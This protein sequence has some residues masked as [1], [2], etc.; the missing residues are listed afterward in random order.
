MLHTS[1]LCL[2][3]RA[4][5]AFGPPA[6]AWPACMPVLILALL[7]LGPVGASL[8]QDWTEGV[9]ISEGPTDWW[10]PRVAVHSGPP[11]HN[12][13]PEYVHVV[14]RDAAGTTV[15]YRR[16]PDGGNTWDPIQTLHT[17]GV[18][19]AAHV[20]TSGN[21]VHVVWKSE[22]SLIRYRR[23]LNHGDPDAWE[24]PLF[25]PAAMLTVPG[26][27][28]GYSP[29]V[30]AY[31]DYVYVVWV[32]NQWPAYQPDVYFRRSPN[33]GA[34]WEPGQYLTADG[35]A[36]EENN[37]RVATYGE[38]VHVIWQAGST[39]KYRRGWL[40]LPD[41][42]LDTETMFTAGAWASIATYE[43][44]VWV[45]CAGAAPN[46]PGQKHSTD[47]GATFPPTVSWLGN[48]G[49]HPEVA[50]SRYWRGT[51]ANVYTDTRSSVHRLYVSTSATGE[52]AVDTLTGS[53][54]SV[55]AD[56]AAH[57]QGRLHVAVNAGE[58]RGQI[59]YY[60]YDAPRK[61]IWWEWTDDGAAQ[62]MPGVIEGE[63]RWGDLN[64]D[65]YPDLIY[66][67]QSDAGRI[68]EVYL[69]D[70]SCAFCHGN[71]YLLHHQ[72]LTGIKSVG[73][74]CLDLGDY[75][76]DGDLD[77]V[78]AGMAVSMSVDTPMACVYVNDGTGTFTVD[79]AS[80]LIAVSG[81]SVAWG[82]YDNDGDLDL[83]I[84][85]TDA[86]GVPV[87]RLYK[88]HP[89]GVLTWDTSQTLTPLCAGS[90]EWADY[91]GD[92]DLDL[93]VTGSDSAGT[94]RTIFYENDPVGTLV[95]T[96]SHGLPGVNLSDT[97]W[98]D[99]DNDGD[100]DLAFTGC[101]GAGLKIS[102]VYR[103][104]GAGVFT[105]L[106]V[107]RDLYRSSVAWG[108]FDNDGALDLALCGYDSFG[109]YTEIYRNTGGSFTVVEDDFPGVREGSL[110][111]VDIDDDGNLELFL[112]GADWNNKYA[113]PYNNLGLPVSDLPGSPTNFACSPAPCGLRLQWS[114]ATDTETPSSGLYYN[115]RVGST[116]GGDD[117]FSGTYGTPLMGNLY[118]ATDWVLRIP[119]GTY[120]WSVQAVDTALSASEWP[121]EQVCQFL[122]P[123]GDL[124]CDGLVNAFDIDPFVQCLTTGVPQPGCSCEMADIN[125][126]GAVNAF[127]IDPFVQLLTGGC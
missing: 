42:W 52:T 5:R 18:S 97:A 89:L 10:Y 116:S 28:E 27:T 68:T 99:F 79:A 61:F 41:E 26:E 36:V 124:N 66:C 77:L 110:S 2:L 30:A 64:N 31:G 3:S 11:T 70:R 7:V 106:G 86:F 29:D 65:G 94:L 84:Q 100:L 109:L 75:D 121:E 104:D 38:Y 23:N 20:A 40:G 123:L 54:S 25:A 13:M 55:R 119:P 98:G 63:A 56:I 73:S 37:P 45:D 72:S 1:S 44:N 24:P 101:N 81:A 80:P 91:D 4:S 46:G 96:G 71:S 88:N 62:R 19:V 34:M 83:Y 17:T 92:G 85:G 16:S 103:N 6:R 82:D 126:D 50:A 122:G 35:A 47:W 58:D 32:V 127:D 120:Y 114:G 87:A 107:L 39:V 108:D 111:W 118:E 90:A 8:A 12:V 67:G 22:D 115:L 15:Q 14:W 48:G 9:V 105:A 49:Q 117:V 113:R 95:N 93:L 33:G 112:I 76:N 78:M 69:N 57:R 60:R 43:G 21:I 51:A 59:M 102:D 125:E 53:P 74:D